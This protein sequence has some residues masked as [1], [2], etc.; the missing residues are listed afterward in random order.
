MASL[1][2]FLANEG[3][4]VHYT[5]LIFCVCGC[6]VRHNTTYSTIWWLNKY[7]GALLLWTKCQ[8]LV[9]SRSRFLCETCVDDEACEKHRHLALN[10]TV[11]TYVF[12]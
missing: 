9:L 1:K 2:Y 10:E 11:E 8:T 7:N 4:E 3:G 5:F 6:A 12:V